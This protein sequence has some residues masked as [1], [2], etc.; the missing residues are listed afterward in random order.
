MIKIIDFNF[1]F[2]V[3]EFC[4]SIFNK[5]MYVEVVFFESN[6]FIKKLLWVIG[7]NFLKVNYCKL[8]WFVYYSLG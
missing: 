4:Y 3:Y 5:Y 6:M 1:I 2:M 7:V 8:G